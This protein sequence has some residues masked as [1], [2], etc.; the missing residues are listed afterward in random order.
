M[1]ITP[2]QYAST[3]VY[4]LLEAAAQGR[5]GFDHRLL[6]AI[7]DRDTKESVP[8]LT[9][10]GMEERNQDP[11]DLEED[12]IAILR[13][14]QVPE[15]LPFYL[16]CLRRNPGDVPDNLFMAILQGGEAS[17]EPLLN[18]YQEIGEE[19]GGE[20]GFILAA[21]RKPDPRILSI[22][23]D[24]LEYDTSDGAIS[25]G[26]YGDPAARPALE[27]ILAETPLDESLVRR[28]IAAA[29]EQLGQPQLPEKFEFDIWDEYP[30][31]AGPQ[32]EVL[33]ESERLDLL[34]SDS[35]ELRAQ[36]VESFTSRDLSPAARKRILELAGSDPD[37]RVRGCCWEVL[38]GEIED[39]K[40]S[41]AMFRRL[42]D[43]SVPVEE[44]CG[45]LVGL[46]ERA[47]EPEIR[48]LVEALYHQPETRAKAM[49]AM[50][51]SL[52]R[53]F[54]EYFPKHLDDQDAEIRRHAIWG[55]G[56]LGIYASSEKL[57]AF[58]EDPDYRADALFA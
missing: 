42:A 31:I 47:G 20:I 27:K 6:H 4:K 25:L 26:L 17:I 28:D 44:R 3:P 21:F 49:E 35:G 2:D 56:Y 14:L 37:P 30:G 19:E 40:I 54:S 51:R 18:L 50:W 43:S 1:V 7:I 29:I 34:A 45:A 8:D 5:I 39:E 16:E 36:I 23:L 38:S 41:G 10:F 53:E 24:R 55:I 22:L 9:R 32:F 46:A 15:A 58:F 48:P 13:H 33:S 11:I 57:I 52:D 12:L